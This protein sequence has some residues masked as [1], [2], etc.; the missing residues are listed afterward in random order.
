MDTTTVSADPVAVVENLYR[1]FG[2][3]DVDAIVASMAPTFDWRFIGGRAAPYSGRFTTPAEL[4][5]FFAAVGEH[6]EILTFEPREILAQGNHVTV[7]GWE[8]TRSRP[9]GIVFESEW[10]HVFTVR[11]GRVARFWGML[12]TE[13]SA[14]AR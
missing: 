13:A 12:D 9:G 11:D 2:R 7:L 4:R 8:R 5:R 6:D 3:G 1:A 10:V 14:R